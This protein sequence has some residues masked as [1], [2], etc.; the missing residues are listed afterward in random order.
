MNKDNIK[1]NMYALYEVYNQY[2]L[3]YNFYQKYK[4][5]KNEED[6]IR[7]IRE[8][9]EMKSEYDKVAFALHEVREKGYG[10]VS[11]GT[12]ELTLAEPKIVK[13]GGR[14]GVKLKASAPSIHM[15]CNKQRFLNA[16]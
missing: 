16:A 5:I 1:D 13:Q 8:L 9:S 14:F 12:D 10:I 6:L 11:P 7:L 4:S 15:I 2:K 3:L